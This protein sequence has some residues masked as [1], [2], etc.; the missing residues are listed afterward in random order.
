VRD[1]DLQIAIVDDES[2]VRIALS[3]LLGAYQMVPRAFASGPELF[4]ALNGGW[5]PDCLVLDMQMPGCSGLDVQAWLRD[6]GLDI[7]VIIITGREDAQLR[8]RSFALGAR[9]HLGKPMDASVLVGV[10]RD[11]VAERRVDAAPQRE[12]SPLLTGAG[13]S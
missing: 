3:R 12:M 10:I 2:S 13:K 7:P 9:A 6:H 11:A 1:I 4:A 8:A 5:D